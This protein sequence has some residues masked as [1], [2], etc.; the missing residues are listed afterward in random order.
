MTPSC[1]FVP[2]FQKH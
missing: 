1:K 2:V